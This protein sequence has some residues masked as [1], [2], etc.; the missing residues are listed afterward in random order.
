M[1]YGA[2]ALLDMTD[3]TQ[4]NEPRGKMK[5]DLRTPLYLLYPS[6]HANAT[7][8]QFTAQSGSS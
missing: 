6:Y 1:Q 4:P 2:L 3:C 8:W 5:Q 7:I